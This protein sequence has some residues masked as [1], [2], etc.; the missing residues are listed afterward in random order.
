MDQTT[1]LKTMDRLWTAGIQDSKDV[2]EIGPDP[3]IGTRTSEVPGGTPRSSAGGRCHQRETCRE[4]HRAL[5]Q[6]PR[7]EVRVAVGSRQSQASCRPPP[8]C[9]Y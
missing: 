1:F 4:H 5:P 6:L 3:A 8:P 9:D 7:L 2:L